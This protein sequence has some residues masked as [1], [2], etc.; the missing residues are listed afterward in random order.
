MSIFDS[1]KNTVIDVVT[2]V[3]GEEAFWFPGGNLEGTPI[4]A[5][6]LFNKHAVRYETVDQH[7][8]IPGPTCEFKMS[9]F[10][11]IKADVD[12]KE[13]AIIRIQGFDYQVLKVDAVK[14][15]ARDGEVYVAYLKI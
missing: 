6:V 5:Q 10:P 15:A 1:L 13:H 4:K 7:F 2:S 9:D 12:E 8:D 3:M 14:S 11:G